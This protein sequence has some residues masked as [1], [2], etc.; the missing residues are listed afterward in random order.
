MC[1]VIVAF[2]D[3]RID[4]RN[5]RIIIEIKNVMNLIIKILNNLESGFTINECLYYSKKTQLLVQKTN[6]ICVLFMAKNIE[7]IKQSTK[8]F[9]AGVQTIKLCK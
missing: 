9:L 1:N 7:T 2:K 8:A 3:N 5:D 4:N 6:F